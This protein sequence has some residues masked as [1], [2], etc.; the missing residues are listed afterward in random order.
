MDGRGAEGNTGLGFRKCQDGGRG[1]GRVGS[2]EGPAQ[3]ETRQRLCF[4]AQSSGL[5]PLPTLASLAT[6]SHFGKDLLSE[7]TAAAPVAIFPGPPVQREAQEPLSLRSGGP[8]QGLYP[9]LG[10]KEGGSHSPRRKSERGGP[11]GTIRARWSWVLAIV[12][13]GLGFHPHILWA[14]RVLRQSLTPAHPM[15]LPEQPG[16]P[17]DVE[18]G[19]SSLNNKPTGSGL[20]K[21]SFGSFSPGQGGGWTWAPR[22]QCGSSG[23]PL[24]RPHPLLFQDHFLGSNRAT[25]ALRVAQQPMGRG[26]GAACKDT[27]PFLGVV[28]SVWVL[29]ALWAHRGKGL[30]PVR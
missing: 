24:L 10:M 17:Q 23:L 28:L 26:P 18:D 30:Q 4:G 7:G 21:N 25:C 29:A 19:K 16:C 3:T 13:A 12:L 1:W 15:G 27:E 11:S 20:C 9:E 2:E 14:G 6:S 5:A 8:T 22:P